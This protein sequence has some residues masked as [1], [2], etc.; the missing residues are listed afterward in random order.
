MYRQNEYTKTMNPQVKYFAILH[1]SKQTD[2]SDD[3]TLIFSELKNHFE[4]DDFSKIEKEVVRISSH[5]H[6]Y[7]LGYLG[8]DL[9][10]SVEKLPEDKPFH[11][12]IPRCWFG[13]FTKPEAYSNYQLPITNYQK[14][15][16]AYIK[17][18]MS[19][20][21]YLQ[22]VK[23]IQD[24]ISAGDIYQANL[25][26]K[27]YGEFESEVK[28]FEIFSRLNEISPAP[29]S[30][31]IKIDDLHIISASP[32]LFIR[33][34]NEGNAVTCPIKGSAGKGQ[35]VEL[36]KSEK[37]ISENLMI[38]DL[39]RS[40]FS[41]SCVAGS[42]KVEKLFDVNEFKTISHMSSMIK[43]KL[44]FAHDGENNHTKM[45]SALS[46]IKNCFPPGSMT[47]APK[48]RAMEI[49]SETEKH[50]RGIYSGALG[51]FNLE[52]QELRNLGTKENNHE[53]STMN[54]Q[55]T[56]CEFSVVIRTLIIKGNKFEFQVG[57]G[58]IYDSN[59]EAEWQET[60]LKAKPIAE[61]LGVFKEVNKI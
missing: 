27:F 9:K 45:L 10:N 19:K 29:Y 53:P 47:G 7:L 61:S 32:E 50:Q 12:E 25:T 18:N 33:V 52:A 26:R 40:D 35:G 24:Y 14:P 15:K 44:N 48:I 56:L 4:S 57:G 37:D 2:Y 39:M 46:L 34:D 58:I 23:K 43:G 1:T 36:S 30:A 49:I 54:H 28:P 17:S 6:S 55:Q 8:Y 21:E 5:D 60:M 42:V 20:M 13:N 51:Y 59:P 31:Y 22:K 3:K 41:R 16:I 38:T 11:I